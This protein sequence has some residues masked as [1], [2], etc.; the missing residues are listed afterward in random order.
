MAEASNPPYR[1]FVDGRH[2]GV[3]ESGVNWLNWPLFVQVDCLESTALLV[4]EPGLSNAASLHLVPQDVPCVILKQTLLQAAALSG[5]SLRF[6]TAGGATQGKQSDYTRFSCMFPRS[7]FFLRARRGRFEAPPA[8]TA[9]EVDNNTRT[10]TRGRPYER[11][12]GQ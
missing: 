9:P 7:P 4:D 5:L 1:E 3:F 10:G 8:N 2:G 6:G 11:L 12:E